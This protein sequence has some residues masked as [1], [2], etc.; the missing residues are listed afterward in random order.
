MKDK[1]LLDEFTQ[2]EISSSI[3]YS[4]DF[5]SNKFVDL[6]LMLEIINLFKNFI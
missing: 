2:F 4:Y 3:N 1:A 6:K 5:N